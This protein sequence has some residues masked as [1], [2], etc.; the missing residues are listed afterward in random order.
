MHALLQIIL[1]TTDGEHKTHTLHSVQ[2]LSVIP[3]SWLDGA[4]A[5][6]IDYECLRV[7][8]CFEGGGDRLVF[9]D[10]E[11]LFVRSGGK[12]NRL[13][14]VWCDRLDG[15]GV[16]TLADLPP[17]A[18]RRKR[19]ETRKMPETLTSDCVEDL[20]TWPLGSVMTNTAK[21]EGWTDCLLILEDRIRLGGRF[22]SR[23]VRYD[24]RFYITHRGRRVYLSGALVLEVFECVGHVYGYD[25]KEDVAH[26]KKLK[27][28]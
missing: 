25:R 3:T 10:S 23:R 6:N 21:G 15:V 1:P 19:S 8:L 13:P 26:N 2:P 9:R 27:G 22:N 12:R 28:Y 4:K 5:G 24:G 20:H 11:G 16:W 14:Q 7:R 17:K 18:T